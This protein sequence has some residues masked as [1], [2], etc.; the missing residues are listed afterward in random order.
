MPTTL[1]TVPGG[2]CAQ[3]AFA[4]SAAKSEF[5]RKWPAP[6]AGSTDSF[7]GTGRRAEMETARRRAATMEAVTTTRTTQTPDRGAASPRPRRAA[8][9]P[10]GRARS[11]RSRRRAALGA[12]R[13][14]AHR[15][16]PVRRRGRTQPRAARRRLHRAGRAPTP[17]RGRSRRTP[18]TSAASAYLGDLADPDRADRA[19]RR[20]GHRQR[21]PGR[22]RAAV[23]A[24]LARRKLEDPQPRA[25]GRA[26]G[27][28]PARRSCG[29]A[30]WRWSS[31]CGRA[32]F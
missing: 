2:W 28:R 11:G 6:S 5:D 22:R 9:A 31:T 27:R 15:R 14:A 20:L 12:S 32:R 26:H 21:R 13:H 7:A 23:P 25:R 16:R 8:R 17:T 10:P 29:A 18:A 19:P 4:S 3:P 30:S 1:L 24:L